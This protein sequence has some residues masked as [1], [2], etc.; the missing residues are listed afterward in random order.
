MYGLFFNYLKTRQVT[1]EFILSLLKEESQP[2]TDS[3]GN[4]FMAIEELDFEDIADAIVKNLPIH[5]V[6]DIKTSNQC[7][8]C[9]ST[10]IKE[11]DGLF[12]GWK[13]KKCK[14]LFQDP[15]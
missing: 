10:D 11:D 7:P 13:C 5:D 15:I 14:C 9:D 1:K 6:S 2:I 8:N 12:G 4:T 3:A